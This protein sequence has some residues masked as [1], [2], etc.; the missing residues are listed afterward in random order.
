MFTCDEKRADSSMLHIPPCSNSLQ[1]RQNSPHLLPSPSPQRV[2]PLSHSLPRHHWASAIHV[3]CNYIVFLPPWRTAS[4]WATC[5]RVCLGIK[6][7]RQ[8]EFFQAHGGEVPKG[9]LWHHREAGYHLQQE[10]QAAASPVLQT[11]YT[12]SYSIG[13]LVLLLD[14]YWNKW[15]GV[16]S[17]VNKEMPFIAN[18]AVLIVW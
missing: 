10:S 16:K 2:Q 18:F 14:I 8:D 15:R 13:F 12:C 3:F 5:S 1:L 4:W 9:S 17:T 6:C 11:L 7:C